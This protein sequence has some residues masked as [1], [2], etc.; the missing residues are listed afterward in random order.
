[1][2]KLALILLLFVLACGVLMLNACGE[3]KKDDDSK[4]TAEDA[5]GAT[6][7]AEETTP[8]PTP[9]PT[10]P[11]TTTEKPPIKTEQVAKWVFSAEDPVFKTGNHMENF[12]V[13]D[14]ILKLTSIGGDPFMYSINANLEM[15]AADVDLIKIKGKNGSEA[16]ACQLFFV[17][18]DDG[19]WSEAMSIRAE[20]WNSDGEDWEEIV[21]DTSDCDLWDGTIKQLRFDPM[22]AEGDFE[23]E[24][25]IFEKIVK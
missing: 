14:G 22:V 4:A 1:M 2:K 12:R 23:M 3:E 15:N 9:A 19:G 20:W 17:T 5:G 16:Y 21:L 13:E 24:Y 10:E 7:A 18:N 25:M 6:E 11:P 8:A